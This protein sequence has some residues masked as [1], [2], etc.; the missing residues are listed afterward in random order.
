MR[1]DRRLTGMRSQRLVLV[2]YDVADDAVR[3]K[4]ASVLLDFGR[5]VQLSVFECRLTARETDRL[6]SRLA[7]LLR[8][9]DR[10]LLQTLCSD[11]GGRV[12]SDGVRR[13]EFD[14]GFW[15]A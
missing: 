8:A 14:G 11:C 13:P 1:G 9:G 15:I 10:L 6:R 7:R 12:M 5:R 4:V 2:A 3:R